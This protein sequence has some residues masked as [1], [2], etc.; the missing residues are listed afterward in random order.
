MILVYLT[1]DLRRE[2]SWNKALD[3]IYNIAVLHSWCTQTDQMIEEFVNEFKPDTDPE[4]IKY[5][6]TKVTL[7]NEPQEIYSISLVLLNYLGYPTVDIVDYANNCLYEKLNKNDILFFRKHFFSGIYPLP[8]DLT[9]DI[10]NRKFLSPKRAIQKANIRLH[11]MIKNIAYRPISIGTT[12]ITRHTII[13]IPT[14]Q[15]IQFLILFISLPLTFFSICFRFSLLN[16]TMNTRFWAV[17]S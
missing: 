13:P 16:L 11:P 15:L 4:L 7:E 17:F 12:I 6:C 2:M 5:L 9:Y 10:T 14:I 1:E 3:N 8:V